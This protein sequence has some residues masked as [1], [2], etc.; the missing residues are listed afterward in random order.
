MRITRTRTAIAAAALGAIAITGTVATG[1]AGAQGTKGGGGA[2]KQFASA[3]SVDQRTCLHDNGV[4][5]PGQGA[6]LEQRQAFLT[7]LET[8]AG[9]CSITLPA[10]IERKIDWITSVDQTQFDCVKA[11]V[12]RPSEHTPEARAQ[13]KAELQAAAQSCG[14]SRPAA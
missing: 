2:A 6:T 8:A 10:R 1:I 11:A 12:T 13:F 9:T 7:N 5:R 3:L 14:I 4:V